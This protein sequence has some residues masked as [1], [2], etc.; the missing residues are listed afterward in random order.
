M[1]KGNSV[2]KRII[3][4][5]VVAAFLAAAALPTSFAFAQA[6]LPENCDKD[7]GVITCTT[8]E[9]G[10]NPK[11]VQAATTTVKGSF[12]AAS[13]GAGQTTSTAEDCKNRPGQTEKCPPGQF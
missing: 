1:R 13:P 10:K 4:L 9:T 2:T 7:K 3:M 12:S 8:T 6:N 11:F 5:F